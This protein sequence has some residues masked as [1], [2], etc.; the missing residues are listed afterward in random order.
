M[1]SSKVTSKYQ[2][3]IPKEVRRALHLEKADRIIYRILKDNTVVI[4][5]ASPLDLDYLRS[6]STT[7][8]EWDSEEDDRA[9]R[10]L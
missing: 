2:A 6:I 10:D 9:F 5:R 1:L 8:N 3:T 4:S 7:L